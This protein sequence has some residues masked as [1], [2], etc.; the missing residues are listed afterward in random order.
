MAV[1]KKIHADQGRRANETAVYIANAAKAAPGNE[2]GPKVAAYGM[3]NCVSDDWRGAVSE[4]EALGASH[5]GEAGNVHAHWIISLQKGEQF[6]P[7][8]AREA[9]EI[10]LRHQGMADH[11]AVY[12]MHDNTDHSH[13]HILVCRVAPEPNP[14]GDYKI[15][16]KGATIQ[17]EKGN[18]EV[19][20]AHV[21]IAEICLRQ[22][23][24]PESNARYAWKNGQHVRV[25]RQ[26]KSD[27]IKLGSRI[28]S[29][30]AR[31]GKPHPKRVMAE[32]ALAEI[33]AAQGDKALAVFRL[34]AI[35]ITYS[36]VDYV[37]NKGRRHQGGKISGEAGE[38]KISSL[39]KADR[40]IAKEP[41]IAARSLEQKAVNATQ[42]RSTIHPPLHEKIS[43]HEKTLQGSMP[44]TSTVRITS[45]CPTRFYHPKLIEQLEVMRRMVAAQEAASNA[46][47]KPSTAKAIKQE[48]KKMADATIPMITI[49]NPA[50][51]EKVK[52]INEDSEEKK[53]RE[54]DAD[55]DRIRKEGRER[56]DVQALAEK[57]EKVAQ[58]KQQREKAQAQNKRLREQQ[59]DLEAERKREQQRRARE[60]ARQ[61]M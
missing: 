15:A 26:T 44:R 61:R 16:W 17:S 32:A 19:E 29:W 50:D 43:S 14:K 1:T 57:E 51:A 30:E 58:A 12:T 53:R 2:F 60:R 31:E 47:L 23:W 20:S 22:G 9:T 36:D 40:W 3:L 49:R 25:Q 33:H 41:V 34:A 28:E 37:D 45:S 46:A 54:T 6:S 39:P 24:Q 11:P 18:N 21:A 13:I 8:Q 5:K 10:F 35:G 7:A 38:V 59:R 56:R 27:S 48:D 4:L 42:L 55:R 52:E